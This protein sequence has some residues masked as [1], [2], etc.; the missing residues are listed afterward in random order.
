[1]AQ[2]S[3]PLPDK[4]I[5]RL[6]DLKAYRV[7]DSAPEQVF[8]DVVR[9]ARSLFDVA[10]SVVSLIDDDR[11]W[12][13]A[14]AGL[15]VLQTG[16]DVAFCTYAILQTE[17]MVVADA[18][19]DARF[20]D[21]ALVTGAPFIRFY[22]G[23]PL[24]TPAGHNIGT[25][26]IFDPAPRPDGF[27]RTE[28]AHLA[29]LARI[30]MERLVARQLQMER[31]NNAELVL[32]IA[33]TLGQAAT[34]L[35]HRARSMVELASDGALQSDAAAQGVRQLILMGNKVEEE[36]AVVS[37]DIEHVAHDADLMR[38][39][40]Q[41]L[42]RHLDGIG[43]VSAEISTIARQTKMLALNASI[44]A[45]RAGETGRGFS[46][47]ANEV[48]QLADRTS[49][50]THHILSELQAI[51]CTVGQVIGQCDKVASRVAAMEA[52]SHR[53]KS[54]TALQVTT[55]DHIE[56][57]VDETVVTARDIGGCARQVGEH[58]STVLSQSTLLRSHA[59]RLM[60]G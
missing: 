42:A 36:V 3:Y 52:G 24:T 55:R 54:T 16:R 46:V 17:V 57:E 23:A 2:L 34:D 6:A 43:A 27:S 5:A 18:R 30:V 9:L 22:A 39:E 32:A 53:I 40:V 28:R 19:A 7:L 45:A 29:M 26:C 1:M 48:R 37:T 56:Q 50:A 51:E 15:D 21:N 25:L 47:V 20:A 8:D 10:T 4:E 35:D 60:I 14:K 44:E 33:D 58:S 41:G 38:V 11:Q 49:D 12:F 31:Q 59:E 13:K